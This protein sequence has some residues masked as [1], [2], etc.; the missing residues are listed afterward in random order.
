L[1]STNFEDL[2]PIKNLAGVRLVSGL[3]DNGDQDLDGVAWA[4]SSVDGALGSRWNGD[5]DLICSEAN[6]VGDLGASEHLLGMERLAELAA[7]QRIEHVRGQG[8]AVQGVIHAHIGDRQIG[9]A[10]G[11]ADR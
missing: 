1:I 6:F 2:G 4:K 11:A 3:V 9:R 8:S 5:R 10:Q 7:D